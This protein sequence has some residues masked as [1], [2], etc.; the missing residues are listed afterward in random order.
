MQGMGRKG[1]HSAHT[2]QGHPE[3]EEAHQT[4]YCRQAA[5][6]QVQEERGVTQVVHYLR[7]R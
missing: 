5:G 7:S 4:P 6:P 3:E 1:H 2:A